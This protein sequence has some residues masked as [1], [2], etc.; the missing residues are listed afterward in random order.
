M[1][2][3]GNSVVDDKS[4]TIADVFAVARELVQVKLTPE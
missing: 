4:L 2:G 1:V 3:Q